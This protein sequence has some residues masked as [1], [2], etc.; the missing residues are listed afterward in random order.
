MEKTTGSKRKGHIVFD[1]DGTLVFS[2]KQVLLASKIV[3][4]K[5]FGYEV[6]QKDFESGFHKNPVKFYKNFKI[7]VSIPENRKK[8]ESFWE[9]ASLKVGLEVPF[10]PN[11][12]ELLNKLKEEGFAIYIWTA[13][14]KLCTHKILK[15]LKIFD[16][17]EGISCGDETAHKPS[18]EGLEVLVGDCPKE[19]VFVVGDS[20]TDIQGSKKFGCRVVGA[21]WCPNSEEEVLKRAGADYLV[22]KPLE[23]LDIFRQNLAI[24]N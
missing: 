2:H 5:W 13:R 21:L 7:D 19:S 4:Q 22:A 1:L 18:A 12:E 23:C 3:L 14:D 11:I 6:S 17:F 8:I 24:E 9:E 16:F 20:E 10:F 15:N